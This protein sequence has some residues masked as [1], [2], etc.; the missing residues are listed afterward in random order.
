M[1]CRP[2][3]KIVMLILLVCIL[4]MFIV[5][6]Y[7]KKFYIDNFKIKVTN[8]NLCVDGEL[9]FRKKLILTV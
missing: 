5:T 8:E 3:S 2:G 1:V 7:I 4:R 6:K 9:V